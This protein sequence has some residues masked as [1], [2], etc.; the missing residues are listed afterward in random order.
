MPGILL[1]RDRDVSVDRE[2]F[3]AGAV[4]PAAG[5][6]AAEQRDAAG[7]EVAALEQRAAGRPRRSQRQ[8][9]H[10]AADRVGAVEVAAAAALDLDAID[11]RLRHLAPVDPPAEGVVE[12]Q[13]VGEHQRAALCRA[14][15]AAQRHALGGRIRR[16]RG[17]AA[18]ER[19][20]GNHLQRV[21]ERQRARWSA[22]PRMRSPSP[23][24]VGSALGTSV[25]DEVTLT[26]SKNGAGCSVICT[27]AAVRPA[28]PLI[29]GAKPAAV[30][31]I[32]RRAG[33][34][35]RELKAAVVRR[36]GSR[37]S[38]RRTLPAGRWRP[39]PARPTDRGWCPAMTAPG[40]VA[41][42]RL[43]RMKRS[44]DKRVLLVCYVACCRRSC[45][46]PPAQT[47]GRAVTTRRMGYQRG[48]N[49]GPAFHVATAPAVAARAPMVPRMRTCDIGRCG[50]SAAVM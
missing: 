36:S 39:A 7:A 20:P 28:P 3:P 13:A 31:T 8:Q 46:I 22:D 49:A 47:H 41:V 26:A 29:A 19:E 32:R 44:V 50:A 6:A 25:R 35:D 40:W 21:V 23:S 15:D 24:T 43:M 12:R 14:A 34:L 27:V 33:R 11:R 42:P 9:L 16:A 2:P 37:R 5:A 1:G 30:A 48:P 17:R 45:N 4:S 38:R 18:E 10:D